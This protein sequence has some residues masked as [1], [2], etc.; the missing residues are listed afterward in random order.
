MRGPLRG[1]ER[2]LRTEVAFW[3]RWLTQEEVKVEKRLD[4]RLTD[5][6]VVEC[7]SRIAENDVAIVEVGAGP[8]TTLG[9]A[10]PRKRI[11][12]TATDPLAGEYKRVLRKVGITPP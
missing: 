12:L 8:L 5:S 10:F 6:A 11:F 2:A 9:N 3:E 7:V 4:S 1:R